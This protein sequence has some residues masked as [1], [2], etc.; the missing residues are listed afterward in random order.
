MQIIKRDSNGDPTSFK[1]EGGACVHFQ[2]GPRL[3]VGVN[4]VTADELCQAL[5][6]YS[7]AMC[8]RFPTPAN[9]AQVAAAQAAQEVV[10]VRTKR[11][12]A[13]DIEGTSAPEL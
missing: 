9:R 6:A 2:C 1:F 3:E 4:G 13:A 10:A 11:R 7:E 5:V 8:A 12:E